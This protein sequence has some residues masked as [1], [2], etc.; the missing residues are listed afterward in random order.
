MNTFNFHQRDEVI[1]DI[2]ITLN[3]LSI[4]IILGTIPKNFEVLLISVKCH[5]NSTIINYYNPFQ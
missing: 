3:L 5:I 1:L 4:C 2:L